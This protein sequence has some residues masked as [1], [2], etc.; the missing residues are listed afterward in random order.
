MPCG[1]PVA[2]CIHAWRATELEQ[3]LQAGEAERSLT[4]APRRILSV[5]CLGSRVM[6]S[7]FRAWCR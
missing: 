7:S 3:P 6:D 5:V 2:A 1:A 4:V